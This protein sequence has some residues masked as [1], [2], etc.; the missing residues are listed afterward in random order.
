MD[1]A[2]KKA[3]FLLI[4][5]FLRTTISK[6]P[7]VFCRRNRKYYPIS[8]HIGNMLVKSLFSFSITCCIPS[9]PWWVCDIQ[10]LNYLGSNQISLFCKQFWDEPWSDINILFYPMKHHPDQSSISLSQSQYSVTRARLCQHEHYKWYCWC[11]N[12]AL[13]ERKMVV[14]ESFTWEWAI[15][16]KC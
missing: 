16:L 12:S 9:E 4:S 5:V 2:N 13:V 10:R 3:L 14:V 8:Y 7:G 15:T 11:W 1:N 6:I